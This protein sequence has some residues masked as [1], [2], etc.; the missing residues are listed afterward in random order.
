MEQQ[1]EDGAHREVLD[2][3]VGVSGPVAL[4]IA[5]KT[6]S[7]AGVSIFSLIDE[8]E[9]AYIRVFDGVERSQGHQLEFLPGSERRDV[10]G[11]LHRQIVWQDVEKAAILWALLFLDRG[12]LIVRTFLSRL[13]LALRRRIRRRRVLLLRQQ[14][15]SP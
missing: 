15:E 5:N 10:F 12:V 8:G 7:E 11:I 2:C 3:G 6:L 14:R 13:G 9:N 1:W 4:C